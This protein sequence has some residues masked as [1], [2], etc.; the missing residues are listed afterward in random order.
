MDLVLRLRTGKRLLL[1][2]SLDLNIQSALLCLWVFKFD[3][4]YD[5]GLEAPV[6]DRSLP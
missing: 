3:L 6:C 4:V 5:E 2:Y 1:F